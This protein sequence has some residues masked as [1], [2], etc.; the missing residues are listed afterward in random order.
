MSITSLG[1]KARKSLLYGFEGLELALC[2]SNIKI[3]EHLSLNHLKVGT[4]EPEDPGEAE[5]PTEVEASVK[6]SCLTGGHPDE[7]T[8]VPPGVRPIKAPKLEWFWPSIQFL[9]KQD[10]WYQI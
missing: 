7:A 6:R 10:C 2:H 8:G 3:S 4:E 1:S 9:Q 5:V